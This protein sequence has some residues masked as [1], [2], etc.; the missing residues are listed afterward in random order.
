MPRSKTGKKRSPVDQ[1]S[2]QNAVA[3]VTAPPDTRISIR[4]ACKVYNVKFTT[5]VRNVNKFK[6]SGEDK[7][8]YN[9][10]KAYT[11]KKIFSE[12]EELTLVRY[13]TTIAKMNYGLTKKKVR[14]LAFKFAVANKKNYPHT[15][16]EPKLAGEEWMRLFL[17]RHS[18]ALSI[19]K[20]E[21]TSLSRA[22]SFNQTNVNN[23]FDNLEDVDERFG[24]LPPER[25]WNQ[26]ET[27]ITTVQNPS[28][29]VGPKGVKQLGSMTSAE[30]GQLITLSTCISATGNHIPPMMVF[31]RKNFKDFM[32]KGAPPGTIGGANPSGW[33]TEELYL[34]LM[35]HFIK[36]TKPSKDERVLLLIDNHETH[37]SLQTLQLASEAGVVVLTFP[38]HSSHRLQPLDV[39]VYFPFKAFYNQGVEAWHINN[40]GKTMDIYSVAEVVG[41]A[42]PRAFTTS[43]ITSGFK[44]TGIFPLDRNIFTETDF[45]PSYVTDRPVPVCV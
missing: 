6:A 18:E 38:P 16:N 22:T 19:R 2:I 1:E 34:Q 40:P 29:I 31:P 9:E 23:F 13:I 3:A 43:N 14:E 45:L 11:V 24:P 32:L 35:E 37:L 42:Y 15:W 36:Q 25:I 28:K 10:K 12:E 20:P 30:R 21:K 5:L 41:Q 33:S 27:G 17:K 7:F 8:E 4:E 26:D 39:S 44:K